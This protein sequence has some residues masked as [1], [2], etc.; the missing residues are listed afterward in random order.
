M[1]ARMHNLRNAL[2]V[3][4]YACIWNHNAQFVIVVFMWLLDADLACA[5]IQFS[6]SW[7]L[8][9]CIP[10]YQEQSSSRQTADNFIVLKNNSWNIYVAF[11]LIFISFGAF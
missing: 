6:L 2:L 8:F 4:W 7:D 3:D 10:D 11:I 9:V 1:Q 5:I